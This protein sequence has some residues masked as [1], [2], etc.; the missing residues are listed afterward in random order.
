MAWS[1]PESRSSVMTLFEAAANGTLEEAF[2][3]GTAVGIALIDEIGY[4]DTH[5][6]FPQGSPV[7]EEVN[8]RLNAIKTQKESDP[9][10]WVVPVNVPVLH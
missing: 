7:G 5:I 3:T 2:G 1:S 9:F 4:Q 6:A 8:R 10:G